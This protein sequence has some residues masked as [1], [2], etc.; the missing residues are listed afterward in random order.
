MRWV[1][2]LGCCV[3]FG[4]AFVTAGCGSSGSGTGGGTGPRSTTDAAPGVRASRPGK[5]GRGSS[6]EIVYGEYS[7]VH[8]LGQ[9]R[10]IKGENPTTEAATKARIS[11]EDCKG[12]ATLAH[13]QTGI[14]LTR[15]SSPS[16]PLSRCRLTGAG[17]S[18][19]IF[20]DTGFAAH[21][22]YA[23]R[24]AETVQFNYEDPARVPH[25]VP[26]V[27]EKAAYNADANWIPALGS[28]LAVR[29]NRWLTVTISVAGRSN[30]RL[31]AEA[32]VLARAGFHLTAET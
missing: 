27:G 16:P 21:Q 9:S 17:T 30:R 12:L 28:L 25:P 31:R 20:L 15:R 13:R 5:I 2:L 22:R 11:V 32:A 8:T 26:H 19:D 23:N 24:I 29:G 18:I 1:R 10:G 6:A 14:M 3:G 4:L 7:P